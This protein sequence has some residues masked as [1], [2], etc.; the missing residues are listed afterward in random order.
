VSVR[1]T[2][3]RSR[4][5]RRP[6][7]EVGVLVNV[8][9]GHSA[10]QGGAVDAGCARDPH[11]LCTAGRP[12]RS[13]RRRRGAREGAS[14]RPVVAPVTC[15]VGWGGTGAS[16]EVAGT[17]GFSV[18]PTYDGRSHGRSWVV[19]FCGS[20]CVHTRRGCSS[21]FPVAPGGGGDGGSAQMTAAGDGVDASGWWWKAASAIEATPAARARRPSSVV[22]IGLGCGWPP[23]PSR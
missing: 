10:A 3:A 4:P 1:S 22:T 21:G 14:W 23:T 6:K 18:V 20:Q 13:H 9:S 19:L 11:P 17:G 16:G 8:G 12:G 5:F 15:S 2:L 7:Q